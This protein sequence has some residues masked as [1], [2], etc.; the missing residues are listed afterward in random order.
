[1]QHISNQ[2][3]SRTPLPPRVLFQ[4]NAPPPASTLWANDSH[5]LTHSLSSSRNP[6]SFQ[7]RSYKKPRSF[8]PP[9]QNFVGIS[10]P[11]HPILLD[12]IIL[13]ISKTRI[14]NLAIKFAPPSSYI[15]PPMKSIFLSVCSPTP[16]SILFSSL[17]DRPRFTPRS[18][19]SLI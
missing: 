2:W 12:V 9:N 7:S 16:S 15:F 11:S 10:E 4:Q 6:L 17:C 14:L 13:T 1:M 8:R 3:M 19:V 5:S 18:L